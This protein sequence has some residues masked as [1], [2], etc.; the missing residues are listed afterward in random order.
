MIYSRLWIWY[1]IGG[2]APVSEKDLS[3][4]GSTANHTF[5]CTFDGTEAGLM[6]YYWIR[7]VNSKNDK[8]SWGQMFSGNVQG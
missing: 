1:K 4:V 6:V 5:T 2:T 3:Y 7:W 8:G